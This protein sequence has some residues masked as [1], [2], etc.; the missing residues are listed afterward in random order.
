[1]LPQSGNS[2]EMLEKLAGGGDGEVK[3]EAEKLLCKNKVSTNSGALLLS[4]ELLHR[5]TVMPPCGCCVR[6]S[7]GGQ[8][9]G[10]TGSQT[11][12]QSGGKT[13]GQTVGQSGGKTVG[14]T[15]GQTVGL[16]DARQRRMP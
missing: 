12:G 11:V 2:R 13:V 4:D 9:G 8:S 1:M 14:Q 5:Y 10:K 16:T 7:A 15:V 6:P 3:N